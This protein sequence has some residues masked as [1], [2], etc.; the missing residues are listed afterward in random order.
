[1]NRDAENK[2]IKARI[3]LIV[4]QPFY[5]SLA[6]K[7][8]LIQQETLN[9]PTMATDG[10]KI[11]YHPHFVNELPLNEV[12]FIIA[13]EIGHCV[14]DHVGR[15]NGRDPRIWGY[16]IDYVVNGLLVESG[17][18][19]PKGQGLYD[20]K[21]AGKSA[22]EVYNILM[23]GKGGGGGEGT[24]TKVSVDGHM[25]TPLEVVEDDMSPAELA[26]DWKLATIQAANAAK[27]AGKLPGSLKRFIDE[28]V[29]SQ[30]DWRMRLR[31]F[32]VEETKND[33]SYSRVN[34]RYASL[35]IYLPGLHSEAMGTMVVVTD[36]SGSIGNE[37]LKKFAGEI[38][39]IRDAVRPQRT[40]VIS[41]D[42]RVNHVDD[43]DEWDTFDLKCH[44]GGGTDFRP[45]FCWLEER[46]IEP[47]CLVYLTDLEGPFPKEPPPYPVLW[48]AT[49]AHEAPW[50]ETLRISTEV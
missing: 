9:P 18:E 31:Q 44:G 40:I 17:F 29:A 8:E 20:P 32:C 16:A 34:R 19:M 5:G 50:G 4:H 39:S 22:D 46:E 38:A 28:L 43:L 21:Y 33:Y 11:Y 27:H 7:L 41:C 49:T 23:Q 1:M 37:I 13:H 15:R 42:A 30:T 24:G 26:E 25:D 45:P 12:K 36:D 48:C 47:A 2:M 6:L 14:F 10:R 3:G 35:G